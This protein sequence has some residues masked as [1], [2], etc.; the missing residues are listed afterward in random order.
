LLEPFNV[1]KATKENISKYRLQ[2][3]TN[4]KNPHDFILIKTLPDGSKICKLIH[5]TN[6]KKLK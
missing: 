1:V 3:Y 5:S 4:P 6:T 2:K